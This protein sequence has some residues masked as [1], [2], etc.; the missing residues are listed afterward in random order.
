MLLQHL[1]DHT[2]ICF[3]EVYLQKCCQWSRPHPRARYFFLPGHQL[4]H[5]IP[6]LQKRSDRS[7]SPGRYPWVPFM[8]CAQSFSAA[9]SCSH[10]SRK[11]HPSFASSIRKQFSSAPYLRLFRVRILSIPKSS[12]PFS[13][14]STFLVR[15]CTSALFS[16]DGCR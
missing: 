11:N 1:P 7:A 14:S 10:S 15:F 3:S 5:C 12:R 8:P 16:T 4:L 9:V 6:T 13:V 2:A